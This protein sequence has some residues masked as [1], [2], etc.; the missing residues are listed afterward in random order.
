MQV[1]LIASVMSAAFSEGAGTFTEANG[2]VYAKSGAALTLATDGN[3]QCVDVI[4]GSGATI[5][6]QSASKGQSTWTFSGSADP[7]LTAGTGSGVVQYT[8]KGWRNVNGQGKWV[9]NQN[10]TFGVQSTAYTLDNTAPPARHGPTHGAAL[11]LSGRCLRCSRC[12]AC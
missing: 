1:A 5:A 3:T 10:E 4:D 9:A 7:W 12:S 8:T 11:I 6:T 2:T